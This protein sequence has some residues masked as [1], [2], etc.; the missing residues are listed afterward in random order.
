[1][2]WSV[3]TAFEETLKRIQTHKGVIGVVVIN[4]EGIAIRSTLD[5]TSTVQYAT[6]ISQ[7][8]AKAKS[9]VR[10]IDPQNDL[11]FLRIRSKKH[12]IMV[13]PEKE[14]MLIVIQ[15]PPKE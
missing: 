3:G 14:Y 12:E 13:A 4:K 11:T 8:A 2:V 5:Q 15:E 1:M 9:A 10:D 7:L 6:L